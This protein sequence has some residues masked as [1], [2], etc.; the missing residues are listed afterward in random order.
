MKLDREKVYILMAKL[1]LTQTTLSQKATISRT[2]LSNILNGKSCM[3]RTLNKIAK[4]L[5]T[6]IENIL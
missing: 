4:A 6:E 2:S 3:P 1:E 5:N